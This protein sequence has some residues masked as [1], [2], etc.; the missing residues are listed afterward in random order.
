MAVKLTVNLP[1]ETVDA[2]KKIASDRGITATEALRQMIANQQFLYQA[3]DNGE[4]VLLEK[5]DRGGI[6]ELLM[7]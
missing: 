7:R 3:I 2:L 4:R 6:R 5:P 1:E